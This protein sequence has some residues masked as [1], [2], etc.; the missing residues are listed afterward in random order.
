MTD[1]DNSPFIYNVFF[2]GAEGFREHF[3]VAADTAEDL[4]ARRKAILGLLKEWGAFS[5]THKV[6][7]DTPKAA[8]G[9]SKL[10]KF[11]NVP[12]NETVE[13]GTEKPEPMEKAALDSIA[14]PNA[15]GGE[16]PAEV[17]QSVKQ[18]KT[19]VLKPSKLSKYARLEKE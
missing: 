14:A 16:P 3:K 2:I 10:D 5:D 9:P 11:K 13:L 6:Y 8:A 15:P 4:A 19:D 12:R 17:V 1:S 7:D 18:A